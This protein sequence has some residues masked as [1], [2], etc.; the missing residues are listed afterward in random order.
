MSK[1][2]D[3]ID[4]RLDERLEKMGGLMKYVPA[5]VTDVQQDYLRAD[6]KLIANNAE[7]KGMLN[8]TAEKLTVGQTVTVGYQTMPSSG[9]IVLANGEADLI[10]EG[11]GVEVENA[12]LYDEDNL[13]DYTV[14][15]ELMVDISANTKLYYGAP[16]RMFVAQG[17]LCYMG[18]SIMPSDSAFTDALDDLLTANH[19]YLAPA[20]SGIIS[21]YVSSNVVYR[22]VTDVSVFP[23]QIDASADSQNRV[24]WWFKVISNVTTTNMSTSAVTTNT[25][26]SNVNF[27]T[28][29]IS[30][31]T[32]Y[33]LLMYCSSVGASSPVA[34]LDQYVPYG[35]AGS[36]T[37]MTS[38]TNFRAMFVYKNSNSNVNKWNARYDGRI[39]PTNPQTYMSVRAGSVVPLSASETTFMLGATQ[40]SEPVTPNSGG[41]A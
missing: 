39:S 33:G 5:V 34:A 12:V 38:N 14:D 7:I 9:V 32:E 16:N 31:I 17:M 1:L 28:D 27:Y 22:A 4:R 18:P 25:Y 11:G 36:T 30:D 6:V 29:D 24:R 10:R 3:I 41:G 19:E 26:T 13:H 23:Y 8:K 37:A 35:Y 2:M 15:T 20:Y 21:Y 40:R